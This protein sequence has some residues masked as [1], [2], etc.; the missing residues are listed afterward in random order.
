MTELEYQKTTVTRYDADELEE[1]IKAL[2]RR[3]YSLVHKDVSSHEMKSF[4][5]RERIGQKL[6]Y[7]GS[8]SRQK[9]TA[10]M[11][12]YYRREAKKGD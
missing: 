11:E 12:R 8:S 4:S 10:L 3:G 7:E 1:G 5:Y 6:V 9:H 2:E